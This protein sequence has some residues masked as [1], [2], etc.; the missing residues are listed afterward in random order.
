MKTLILTLMLLLTSCQ[1]MYKGNVQVGR[2][3][4]RGNCDEVGQVIGTANSRQDSYNKALADL[5]NEAALR[6]GNY[7]RILAV[8]AHGAAIR[9]IAYKCQ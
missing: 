7:V 1:S 2:E 3:Y 4:P 6:D 5:R 8:S 9:G